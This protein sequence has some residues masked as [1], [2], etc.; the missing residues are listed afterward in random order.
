[1]FIHL[2]LLWL[3]S[4][5]YPRPTKS[6][7]G[8]LGVVMTGAI[9]VVVNQLIPHQL[10]FLVCVILLWLSAARSKHLN[11]QYVSWLRHYSLLMFSIYI[12]LVQYSQLFWYPSTFCSWQSGAETFGPEVQL[13]SIQIV[14][15]IMPYLLSF[16]LSLHLVVEPYRRDMCRLFLLARP[17]EIIAD[18]S[19]D[20][21]KHVELLSWYWLW[22]L[23][24]LVAVGPG[25]YLL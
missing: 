21:Y 6:K 4:L 22:L 12:P 18:I 10:I 19:V 24:L 15:S 17:M 7:H 20:T 16:W 11:S 9:A 3:L 25:F 13:S 2:A 14:I 8:W 1:M 5:I 23:S